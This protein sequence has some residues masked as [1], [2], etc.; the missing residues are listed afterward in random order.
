MHSSKPFSCEVGYP[1][2]LLP[3]EGSQLVKGCET[4]KFNYHDIQLKLFTESHVR[5]D[6][7]P[8]GG[9]NMNGL[10]ER[11]IREIKASME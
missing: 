11:K 8:V 9:H 4:L 2:N 3:D 5:L 10:V 6:T 1:K 7:C